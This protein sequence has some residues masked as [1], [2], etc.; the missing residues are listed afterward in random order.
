[1]GLGRATRRGR[2]AAGAG[3]G[4]ASA[5]IDGA[6]AAGAASGTGVAR[7]AGTTAA[8]EEEAITRARSHRVP[9]M[10]RGTTPRSV[11][12]RLAGS[13]RQAAAGSDSARMRSIPAA[14]ARPG[15]RG[16]PTEAT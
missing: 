11:L 1:M 16:P 5:T 4:A 15:G 13:G 8:A 7:G 12:F 6:A 14:R 10:P 3:A 9:A 2:V